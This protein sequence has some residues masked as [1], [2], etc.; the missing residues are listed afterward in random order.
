MVATSEQLKWSK[1]KTSQREHGCVHWK[2]FGQSSWQ[3]G[4]NARFCWCF[5]VVKQPIPEEIC[6]VNGWLDLE[7]FKSRD[8]TMKHTFVYVY[9]MIHHQQPMFFLKKSIKS[10]F[11]VFVS[12]IDFHWL[13]FAR[14]IVV[15]FLKT[16][17]LYDPLW[18]LFACNWVI[19]F[20]KCINIPYMD[21]MG[22]VSPISDDSSSP[23]EV[24]DSLW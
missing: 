20:G 17:P 12:T 8:R 1:A 14:F 5:V 19:F 13:F 3:N 21:S 4:K 23:L 2:S 7:G 24:K 18:G 6:G 22:I 10:W 16:C 15:F 9:T 11:E